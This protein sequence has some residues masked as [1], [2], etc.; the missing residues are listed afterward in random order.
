M[1]FSHLVCNLPN[2]CSYRNSSHCYVVIIGS[3]FQLP[4]REKVKKVFMIY[5]RKVGSGEVEEKGNIEG[6]VI[7]ESG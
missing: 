5:K 6:K 2:R 7:L 1:F 3:V 4:R